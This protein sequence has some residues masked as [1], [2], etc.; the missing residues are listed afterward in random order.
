MSRSCLDLRMAYQTSLRSL[1]D[2]VR[3]HQVVAE[4]AKGLPVPSIVRYIVGADFSGGWWSLKDSS[5]IFNL[6]QALRD[7]DEVLVCK[8][9]KGKVTFV[10]KDSL[11][12]L[13]SLASKFPPGA[14]DR[15]EEQHLPNGRHALI[16]VPLEVWWVAT[17]FARTPL[18]SES[19]AHAQLNVQV[20]GLGN[21]VRKFYARGSV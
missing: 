13:V 7:C 15:V 11:L 8:L 4:A 5:T 21:I 3:T 10:H 14:L 12:P 6:L 9:A 2:F 17:E 19:A 1:L 18:L 16:T 20:P